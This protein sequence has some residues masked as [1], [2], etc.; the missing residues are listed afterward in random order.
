[1][2]DFEQKVK[3]SLD[4]DLENLD[5]ETRQLLA[6]A[7]RNALNQP[8][9]TSWLNFKKEYWLSASTVALCSLLAV[10]ILVKPASQSD[11]VNIAKNAQQTDVAEDLNQVAALE[12]LENTDDIDT[13][14]D[15]DF[16]LWVDEALAAEGKENAA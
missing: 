2:S 6:N 8:Q 10:F 4:R 14:T 13:A 7:R 5:A 1:M 12:I 16:Y 3:V 11:P 15:P 9:K